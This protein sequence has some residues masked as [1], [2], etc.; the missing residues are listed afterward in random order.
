[1]VHGLN[2][3]AAPKDLPPACG[4]RLYKSS[5]VQGF[6]TIMSF[7]RLIPLESNREGNSNPLH[8]AQFTA[9]LVC[10]YSE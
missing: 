1:M 8:S 9:H 7:A 4:E 2:T 6:V 10:K 5:E 3:G